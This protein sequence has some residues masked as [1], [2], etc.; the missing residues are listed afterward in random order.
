MANSAD[1]DHLASSEANW[2]GSTQFAKAGHILVQQ[3]KGWDPDQPVKP[4]LLIKTTSFPLHLYSTVSYPIIRYIVTIKSEVLIFTLKKEISYIFFLGR[5]YIKLCFLELF[6]KKISWQYV[7]HFSVDAQQR[8]DQTALMY[9]LIWAFGVCLCSE[10]PS[11]YICDWLLNITKRREG[12]I[13][14]EITHLMLLF[15]TK[16]L[17]V[18]FFEP[19]S[20]GGRGRRINLLISHAP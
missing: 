17:P 18:L 16:Y 2:S 3:D 9:R 5:Q 10:G 4:H 15:V 1:P 7:C 13:K 6:I 19:P 12:R 20:V 14:G 8:P 11:S